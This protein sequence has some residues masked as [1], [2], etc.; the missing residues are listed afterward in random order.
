MAVDVIRSDVLWPR[1]RSLAPA[2]HACRLSPRRVGSAMCQRRRRGAAADCG[3][4]A[5]IRLLAIDRG[6]SEL[7]RAP[8]TRI[9]TPALDEVPCPSVIGQRGKSPCADLRAQ[10]GGVCSQRASRAASQ[11]SRSAWTLAGGPRELL[12]DGRPH[13]GRGAGAVA[14]VTAVRRYCLS[15]PLRGGQRWTGTR[16]LR[17]DRVRTWRGSGFGAARGRRFA[18]RSPR[19]TTNRNGR[20]SCAE[21]EAYGSRR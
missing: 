16:G 7:R 14:L 17:L 9:D 3:S 5:R 18:R 11:R 2:L 1:H 13:R 10:H 12:R 8:V 21:A 19:E 6:D 4:L 15:R 20:V